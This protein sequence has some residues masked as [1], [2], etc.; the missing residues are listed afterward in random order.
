MRV[1]AAAGALAIGLAGVVA[2]LG[3]ASLGQAASVRTKAKVVIAPHVLTAGQEGFI[4]ITF[5]NAGPSTVN[6][7]FATVEQAVSFDAQGN[8]VETDPMPLP[9]SAFSLSLPAGCNVV[10]SGNP[11]GS[12]SSITC[13]LGQVK[14]GTVQ[15]FI[16]FIAPS[17]VS[18]FYVFVSISYDESKGTQ[19]QDTATDYDPYWF[20]LASGTDTKGQCTP[21]GGTLRAGDPQQETALTYPTSTNGPCT[22]AGAGVV[23][24]D[25]LPPITDVTDPFNAI[26]FVDFFGLGQV[27]VYFLTVPQGIN[28]NNLELFELA[29]FPISLGATGDG[30][31]VPDCAIVGGQPQIPETQEGFVSCVVEVDNIPGGGLVATLLVEGGGDPGWGGIG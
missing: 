4:A 6:H 23:D 29:Q 17:G 28:K 13:D 25:S 14:P 18:P 26:S 7:A 3:V 30:A 24:L 8:V 11:I 2:L 27:Q 21:F 12:S 5:V 22:P 19:K 15:R 16:R 20:S 31:P 9:A 10:A 1:R